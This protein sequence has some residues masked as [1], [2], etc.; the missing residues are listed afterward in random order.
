[1]S[2]K[3]VLITKPYCCLYVVISVVMFN[4]LSSATDGMVVEGIPWVLTQRSIAP[5]SKQVRFH[6]HFYAVE[7]KISAIPF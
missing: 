4:H 7:N 1:M 6:K 5:G 3:P 2:T